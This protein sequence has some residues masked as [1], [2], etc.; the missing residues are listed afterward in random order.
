MDFLRQLMAIIAI[1]CLSTLTQAQPVSSSDSVKEIAEASKP[2]RIHTTGKQVTIKS[3]KNIKGI[4]VWTSDGH[5]IVEQKDVNAGSYNFRVSINE[6]ILFVR[7]E[8]VD[9][10]TH[11]EKI[12]IQ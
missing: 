2:Y 7:I 10:K 11:S 8:L 5:R 1:T 12:G 9:G 3:T 4:I 6:K